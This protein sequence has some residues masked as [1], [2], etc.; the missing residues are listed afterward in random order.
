MPGEPMGALWTK[1]SKAGHQFFSGTI[2]IGEEEKKIVI[3]YN[4]SKL[5]ENANPK[6]PDWRIFEEKPFDQQQPQ[7][8]QPSMQTPQSADPNLTDKGF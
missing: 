5:K 6:W 4:R 8:S 2:K 7:Q 1:T 3:L